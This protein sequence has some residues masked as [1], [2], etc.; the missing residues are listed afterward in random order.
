MLLLRTL[1]IPARYAV[2]YVVDEYSDMEDSHVARSRDAHSWALA[3]VNNEWQVVETTPS[4]WAFYE[5]S[6]ASLFEPFMDIYS[7][8]SYRYAL[9]QAQ[10]ELEQEETNYNLLYLLIPLITIL[11]WRLFFNQKIKRQ[12][13]PTN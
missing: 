7:W 3:Y 11:I 4:V 12:N 6:N 2:G 13:V 9:F 5:D 8:L 1:G 10:D